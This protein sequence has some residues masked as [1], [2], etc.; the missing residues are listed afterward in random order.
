MHKVIKLFGIIALV[1]VVMPSFVGCEFFPGEPTVR[2]SVTGAGGAVMGATFRAEADGRG[3]SGDHGFEWF[4]SSSP[5]GWGS[6]IGVGP[7]ITIRSPDVNVGDYIY[8]R[9]FNSRDGG[10]FIESNRIGPILP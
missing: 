3:W 2:I 8:A 1:A 7:G 5:T 9:R 10:S 4:R 6:R